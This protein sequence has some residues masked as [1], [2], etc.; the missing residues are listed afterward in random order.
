MRVN[1]LTIIFF[2]VA[3]LYQNANAQEY[4]PIRKQSSPASKDSIFI[5]KIC[6]EYIEHQVDE[7]TGWDLGKS[8]KQNI[9]LLGKENGTSMG[10]LVTTLPDNAIVITF[11]ITHQN[12]CIESS[13]KLNVL[14]RDGTRIE[15]KNNGQPNCKGNHYQL[16]RGP[17]NKEEELELLSLKEIRTVRVWTTTG[18]VD[19]EFSIEQSRLLRNVLICIQ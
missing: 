6:E 2:L 1:V 16:F 5:K 14:F 9:I 8:S 10:I 18:F 4:S 19:A 15:L 3:A 12:P 17:F 11:S 13:G 7:V